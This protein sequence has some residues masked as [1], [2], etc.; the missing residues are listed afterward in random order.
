MLNFKKEKLNDE[1]KELRDN[2]FIIIDTAEKSFYNR[3]ITIS[4]SSR[5]AKKFKAR[6][7]REYE[8]LKKIPLRYTDNYGTAENASFLA[9]MT[10]SHITGIN[11]P[12]KVLM[13]Q[14]M[15]K[16]RQRPISPAD[17]GKEIN[18]IKISFYSQKKEF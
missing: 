16:I 7:I 1:E 10:T 9:F 6:C 2:L 18:I 13:R 4:M 11:V 8:K 12:Y 3:N 15:K 17:L 14:L 5:E